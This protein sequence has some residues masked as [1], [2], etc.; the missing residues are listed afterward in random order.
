MSDVIWSQSSIKQDN[1]EEKLPPKMRKNIFWTC[2][3]KHIRRLSS[4]SWSRGVWGGEEKKWWMISIIFHSFLALKATESGELVAH[5]RVSNERKLSKEKRW[6]DDDDE[7]NGSEEWMCLIVKEIISPL[8]SVDVITRYVSSA[9]MLC[10]DFKLDNLWSL[11]VLVFIS[12]LSW[13]EWNFKS[14][15]VSINA[16]SNR[17]RGR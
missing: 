9:E 6:Y 1:K 12:V 5:W 4:V 15:V 14:S 11:G 2:H 13:H 7:D 16:E 10:F 8:E 17:K 3:L